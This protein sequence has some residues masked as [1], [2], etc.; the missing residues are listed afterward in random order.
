MGGGS[1]TKSTQQNIMDPLQQTNIETLLPAA[2]EQYNKGPIQ[3]YQGNAVAGLNPNIEG[4]WNQIL[5]AANG[6]GAQG[7]NYAIDANNALLNSGFLNDVTQIPGY[8]AIAT[9]LE[10]R[11]AENL[12][13]TALPNI[14][15]GA[16]LA[17]QYGGSKQGLGSAAA[18]GQV[19]DQL[20]GQIGGLQQNLWSQMLGAQQNAISAAPGLYQAS[21][22]PGQTMLDVGGQQRG[23]EQQLIDEAMRKWNF[24]QQ[25]PWVTMSLLKDVTGRIGEY[26][27]TTK[28]TSKTSSSPGIGQIVG[29][30][31]GLGSM[32]APFMGGAGGGAAPAAAYQPPAGGVGPYLP[33]DRRLKTNVQLL[34]KTR[35]GT[36]VYSY[37]YIWGGSRHIGVMADEVPE[38]SFMTSTGFLWVD[39]SKVR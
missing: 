18:T 29:G 8:E 38:A 9:D 7:I 32:F 28:T 26:G 11:A 20:A 39:Y 5:Q 17:G 34:G 12:L 36:N 15:G 25:S 19:Q 23:Y 33:S 4:G 10:R 13:E 30:M 3:Y 24:E 35:G 31:M 14:R 6:T 22:M 27:S 37:N 16:L 1:K 2:L 21:L